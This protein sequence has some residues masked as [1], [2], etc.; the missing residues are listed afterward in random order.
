MTTLGAYLDHWAGGDGEREA[1]ATT[2]SMLASAGASLA[3]LISA[4]PLMG[5]FGSV[6]GNNT[7]GD[8][9]KVL[10]IR[11]N[12]MF[13]SAMR[14]APV[15][16][17]VS[18]EEATPVAL[19]AGAPLALALDPLDGSD[20]ID[21]NAPMGTV[22]SLLPA[23]EGGGDASFL[24]PGEGQRGAGFIL[25]G[26]YTTLAL[27]VGAGTQV[28]TLDR[29]ERVFKLTKPDVKIPP[30]RREYAIN[31]SNA[32]HWPL[33]VRAYVEECL[34]GGDGPRGAD[35]NTRWLGCVVAEAYRIL[36]RGG[37]YLYPGDTR[38]GYERGRLRVLDQAGPLAALV[39]AAGG[40]A[41]DG[42][43]RIL[44]ITPKTPHQKV[45]LIFGSADKVGRVLEM[46]NSSVPQAGQRPLFATR[47]LSSPDACRSCILSFR[48]RVH[49]ARARRR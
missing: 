37:I 9:Q 45:P 29:R 16:E 35:Y 15:R 28:F 7:G 5:N 25:Y 22:F 2:V 3:E 13:L 48:L 14:D 10:D 4:A 21:P 31:G 41:T 43:Q 47:G 44:E 38:K 20:N 26:P 8:A 46:F 27:T 40:R 11:A 17:A 42:Y 49:P 34:A 12:E 19:Q 1:V 33:P 24:Q 30:G 39:E 6:L 32:R 18:E 23:R 36:L